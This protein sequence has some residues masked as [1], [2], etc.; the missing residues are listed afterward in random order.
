MTW[1]ILIAVIAIVIFFGRLANQTVS[2]IEHVG[3][4]GGLKNK[5]KILIEHIMSRNSLYQLKENYSNDIELLC[6]GTK[7]HLTEVK[8]T[9][10]INWGWDSFT[11]GKL[12]RLKWSFDEF[13]NQDEM[14]SIIDKDINIVSL[15]DEGFT[16][17]QAIDFLNISL[18]TNEVEQKK[19]ISDFS[20]KY[21]ELWS[22][23]SG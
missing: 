5:Y 1:I 19:L 23:I 21:P 18:L 20:N 8:K 12:H 14:Y 7:F 9:L 10:E 3:K 4:H 22:K 11:S 17:Q 2:E 15:I 6:T 16:K 13:K